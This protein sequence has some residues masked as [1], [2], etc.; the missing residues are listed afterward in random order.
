[1]TP[2][3]SP[4]IRSDGQV[5]MPTQPPGYSVVPT[6]RAHLALLANFR[7]P[8]DPADVVQPYW[9]EVLPGSV[10]ATLAYFR[11]NG[12]LVDAPWQEVF[13]TRYRAQDLKELLRERGLRVSGKKAELAAR[14]IEADAEGMHQHVMSVKA[15]VLSPTMAGH[16][17][18]HLSAEKAAETQAHDAAFSA[19]QGGRVRK[20]V[21]TI[22]TYERTRLFSRG[23]GIDWH[24]EAIGEYMF[25]QA[26]AILQSSPGI[27]RDVPAHELKLLRPIAALLELTGENRAKPWLPTDLAGHPRLE[28]ETVVRMLLFHGRNT[29][30]LQD[31]RQAG[32]KQVD[33]ATCG[34]DSCSTCQQMDG[35]TFAIDRVPELP[36]PHCT[37]ELGCRCHYQAHLDY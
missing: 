18:K 32:C 19:L 37:H 4:A 30:Q 2:T 31:L 15:W 13:A 21:N 16:V 12:W 10:D 33:V 20:A 26:Q 17:E 9:N 36:N 35:K 3:P 8:S 27:L 11:R 29:A 7:H 24:R 5:Q 14:L 1:M 6:H 25:K 22:V 23:L 34:G 28:I